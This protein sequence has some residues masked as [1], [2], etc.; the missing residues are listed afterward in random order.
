M[1]SYSSGMPRLWEMKVVW[2]S[3]HENGPMRFEYLMLSSVYYGCHT[4]PTDYFHRWLLATKMTKKNFPDEIIILV[5]FM[6]P[7]Y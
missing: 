7:I 3:N 2:N 4:L 1:C 6:Q 5:C